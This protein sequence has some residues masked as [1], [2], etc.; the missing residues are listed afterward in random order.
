MSAYILTSMFPDGLSAQAAKVFRQKIRKRT[1]FAF[2]ASE[3]EK[4]HEK[5]DKYFQF[6][7]SMLEEAGICFEEA[8]VVDG[9]MS[10]EE[11]QRTVA[12]ADVLWLSGGDTPT[13]FGY[14]KKYG[15]VDVIGQHDGV[16]IGM[17][18]GSINMAKIAICTRNCGHEKQEIYPGLGCVDISVEPHFV[19]N[20]VSEELLE[21]SKEHVIYGLCDGSFIVCEGDDLEF[22]GEVYQ[23]S[24]G[25]IAA[26]DTF[27]GKVRK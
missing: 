9:G 15:L 22:Y 12:E 24:G 17:S 19:R 16:V 23:F 25:E 3:F 6:F 13:E 10:A 7:L 18:A 4:L 5:T 26:I 1:R 27:D 2:V 20:P 11:A 8:V 14:F 21:L